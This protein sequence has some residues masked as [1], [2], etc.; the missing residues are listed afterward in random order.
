MPIKNKATMTH[1]RLTKED[2]QEN[3]GPFWKWMHDDF[4]R[5]SRHDN[6]YPI[7][8]RVIRGIELCEDQGPNN[9]LTVIPTSGGKSAI[10]QAPILYKA[11]IKVN[12]RISIVITPLQALM[13]EQVEIV[14]SRVDD[15]FKNKVD[16]IHSGRTAE[17]IG[18]IK[19]RI[20]KKEAENDRRRKEEQEADQTDGE[21][22]TDV[23]CD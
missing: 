17:D 7:Q 21:E 8:K 4:L 15:S 5:L 14:I 1:C 16:F 11:I 6:I 22:E 23:T 20:K 12:N 9:F 19:E 3:D 18:K 2:L 13:Q 10:F